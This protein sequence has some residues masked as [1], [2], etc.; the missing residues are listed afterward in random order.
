MKRIII[1]LISSIITICL[2][3]NVRSCLA[4]D[5]SLTIYNDNFALI[6]DTRILDLQA[7]ITEF[8]FTDVA[9]SI[10]PESVRFHSLDNDKT[11]IVEQNFQFDIVNSLKVLNKYIGRKIEILTRNGH[12]INGTL[13][14]H[15]K[16]QLIIRI[17]NEIRF[18]MLRQIQAIR[19]ANLPK[20]LIIRPTLVWQI[21]SPITGKQK[22]QLDYLA[23]NINWR[24]DYNAELAS[25][26]KTISLTGWVTI[27]NN[28]G[29]DFPKANITLIA[30]KPN[31]PNNV[32]SYGIDYLRTIS[33][34]NVKLSA[35]RGNDKSES[36]SE[37]H[38]YRLPNETNLKNKQIKQIKLI[39]A[40]NVAVR[41]IYLYDGAK[42]QFYPYRTYFTPEFGRN[43]NKKVN[44][45]IEIA[46][47][48]DNNLGIALPQGLA[49]IYKR[50]K[51]RSLEF[52]GEDKIPST[53]ADEKIML[54]LG[55]AFD[56][57]GNRIQTDF[58]RISSH[59]I[60]EAFEIT[61]KNHKSEPVNIIVIEKLYRCANWTILSASDKYRKL[62]ARTIKFDIPIKPNTEK[63][64]TYRVRYEM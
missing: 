17:D 56:I 24:V 32:Y 44:V 31:N 28:S 3:G 22:V 38:L 50:D 26:E 55:D 18:V 12:I 33:T 34:P 63:K 46:N 45:I 54:Y 9:A 51:D 14:N 4:R 37:Y 35:A 8:R 13:L 53:S 58:K 47:N 10:E 43:S 61:L 2:S 20:G 42:V 23:K 62:N 11:R 29:T 64:I 19:L 1:I 39:Q 60:E 6:K 15:E 36:F 16:G 49:R 7:G 21:Y 30:G 27:T 57:T 41:K 40:N 48:S 5:I 59:T 25:D 52:V